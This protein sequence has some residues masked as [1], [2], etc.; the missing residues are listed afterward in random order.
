MRP[1]MFSVYYSL[2]P[3]DEA[4]KKTSFA[5]LFSFFFFCPDCLSTPKIKKGKVPNSGFFTILHLV[6]ISINA[7]EP[8]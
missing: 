2:P 1:Q 6:L 5:F 3:R 4:N 7:V 8:L